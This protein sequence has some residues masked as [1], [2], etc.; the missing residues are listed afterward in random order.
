VI[1]FACPTCRSAL[2]VARGKAGEKVAC[3]HCGQRLQVPV[4]RDKTLLG[5][6]LPPEVSPAGPAPTPP[7]PPVPRLVVTELPTSPARPPREE[8]HEVVEAPRPARRRRRDDEDDEDE[9]GRPRRRFECPE[10]GST[11]RPI[12]RSEISQ[13]GWIVFAVLLVFFFP[14][15]FLGLL[16]KDEYR[17]CADCGRR[18]GRTG[19]RF[20]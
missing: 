20:G 2:A 11:Y 4:P 13:S 17:V 19:Q 6:M 18:L 1:R 3:P 5:E 7:P 10:C 15:C 8:P 14:L 12:T 16:M 9:D